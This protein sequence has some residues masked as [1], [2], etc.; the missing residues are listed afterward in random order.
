[1][2]SFLV[3]LY[4]DYSD[5]SPGVKNGPACRSHLFFVDSYQENASNVFSSE[6]TGPVKVKFH[7]EPHWVGG[8]KVCSLH[9]GHLTKMAAILARPT[10]GQEVMV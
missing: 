9:P 6:T 5:Y 3:D 4:Q 8:T 7:M 1:M 10:S 2:C